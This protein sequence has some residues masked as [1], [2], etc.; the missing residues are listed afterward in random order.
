LYDQAVILELTEEV[1]AENPDRRA[2]FTALDKGLSAVD[3]RVVWVPFWKVHNNEAIFRENVIA[4]KLN[5]ELC[6]SA[7]DLANRGEDEP[8][9]ATTCRPNTKV[10]RVSFRFIHRGKELEHIARFLR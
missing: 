7:N 10:L 8:V 1:P 5:A 2:G 4:S 3:E 6:R 9:N